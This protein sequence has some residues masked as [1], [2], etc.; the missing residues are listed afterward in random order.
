V[1]VI[2]AALDSFIFSHPDFY[3][4]LDLIATEKTAV[5][6]SKVFEAYYRPLR[7]GPE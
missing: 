4:A 1:E 3:V 7:R 6:N 5:I 2:E